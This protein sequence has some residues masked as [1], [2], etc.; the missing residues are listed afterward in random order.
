MNGKFFKTRLLASSVIAGA[1]F[2][3]GGTAIAQGQDEPAVALDSSVEDSTARQET[4]TV[5][6][7]RIGQTNL[8]S[9]VPVSQ[10]DAQQI[11][12]T[13][14]VNTAEILRTLPAAGVSGLTSTNSNFTTTAS[15]IN[16]VDL[17]NLGEDRTLVLVNGRRFVA[18]LPGS[19]IVDF[20][21]IP[22]DFIERIDVI[23]GGA[24]AVY[25]S[26]A[27]AGVVNLILKDDY[28]GFSFSA[29]TGMAE[30]GDL[31]SYR[32]TMT[33]GANFDE[34]RGNAVASISWSRNNGSFFRN[35][36]GQ[37][38]DDLSF[39]AY[40]GDPADVLYNAS[41]YFGAPRFS[42]FSERGRFFG[43]GVGNGTFDETTGTYRAFSSGTD[44]F[45]RQAFRALFTPTERITASSVINYELAPW[46]NF[47]TEIN[48]AST[49]TRAELEPF[50]LSYEDVYGGAI[51]C[52]DLDSNA[53][54]A[55]TCING[56]P[57]LGAFVPE[58]LRNQIRAANPGI[59]DE[60]LKYAFVRRTTE[61]NIRSANN[62]RQT[63]RIVAGF[64]GEFENGL[65][66]ET[67]LNWGRTTQNQESTGQLDVRAFAAALDTTV[68]N[69]E[70]VCADPEQR[71]LG[72]VPINIFGKGSIT[73]D[74]AAWVRADSK[75]DAEI[76]QTVFNAFITGDSSLAGFS[77]PGG[78]AAFVLGYEWRSESSSEIP[79]AL[80]QSGLNGGNVTP[81][82]IGSFEVDEIFGE[83]KLPILADAPF[84]EELTVNLAAR[85]SNYSTV[86]DT[87]AWSSNIDYQP[88]SSLRFRASY[89]EA[90]RAPNIGEA[91]SGLGETF[92]TVSDP[93]DGVSI[94]GGTP[95]RNGVTTGDDGRI[96]SIC[97]ADPLVAARIARDGSFDLTLAERQGTGGFVGG[98]IAGGFDLKEEEAETFT[99]GFVFNPDFNKWLE[100][101]AISVDYFDIEITDAIGTLGRQTSLNRCYG[102]GD[103]TVT[104]FDPT[105][106]FCS[107]VV[108]FP[109]GPSLGA[110]DQVNSF[111]QNLASIKTSGIDLQAS[112]T[113]DIADMFGSQT[114][115][116]ILGFSANYQYLD[117]YSSEAFPGDGFSD[118][119]GDQGL[120]EH[121]GL[122]G[123]VYD[124]GP[125]TLALDTTW[126]GE[127]SDDYGFLSTDFEIGNKFFTDVQARYRV[128]DTMT[129]VFG[130]DNV[131]D[132]FVYTGVGLVG[133]TGQ[134]TNDAVYDSLG[135]RYY[136]GFRLDF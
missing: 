91:F 120:S 88:I 100:P 130:V 43:A 93:C 11:E 41:E 119:V 26:D 131:T 37:G 134:Y 22:T 62:T 116:G 118:S 127:T 125:V 109:V 52:G 89:S 82:T 33:A 15:G 58:A 20:N 47:F 110:T 70:V 101:L 122:F 50:P 16:T 48:Y 87:F 67:S 83:L 111:T 32:A 107:N 55:P 23:T 44:G 24:S 51:Q 34:G 112:Y 95:A 99:I 90:V 128:A 29:Q 79:D 18:G 39:A 81:K 46:A 4:V 86:G 10:F 30:A 36:T 63:A 133:G 3:F 28:E 85:A 1:A 9:P 61:V 57:I 114:D 2:T 56:A 31:E 42:S 78:P 21:Q 96:A 113:L 35:R 8:S 64:D 65:A 129:L 60:D 54:T 104:T 27:L 14:A 132:E 105:S 124:Y 97:A 38:V 77:L 80:S 69:G 121:E 106:T 12:L 136:A 102:N 73:D 19:Q 59:A 126:I 84:A 123:V 98:A 103:D 45:N 66:Y 75:F 40:T 76:E 13:G 92:A 53:A 135:R 117:E 74:A 6:G 5:T 108:R 49:D 71:S 7:T 25:G 72:C 115:Y 94:V 68:V 17:R